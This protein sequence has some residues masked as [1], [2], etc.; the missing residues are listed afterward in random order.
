MFL[1]MG[2]CTS[3]TFED[4]DYLEDLRRQVEELSTT[5]EKEKMILQYI[6]LFEEADHRSREEALCALATVICLVENAK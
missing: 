1:E 2:C 6:A 3:S 4:D 5:K